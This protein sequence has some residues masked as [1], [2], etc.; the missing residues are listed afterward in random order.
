M[1]TNIATPAPGDL[2]GFAT[3]QTG[4]GIGEVISVDT[5]MG[6]LKYTVLTY[7]GRERGMV[8]LYQDDLRDYAMTARAIARNA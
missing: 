6:E 3:E 4:R 1:I 7:E 2:I 5:E 8:E